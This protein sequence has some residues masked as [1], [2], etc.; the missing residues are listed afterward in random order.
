MKLYDALNRPYLREEEATK[1]LSTG[2]T[3]LNYA[4]SGSYKYGLET[5]SVVLVSGENNS[6]R[7]TFGLTVLAEASIN[8]LFSDYTLYY[9]D[10]EGKTVDIRGFLGNRAGDRI[11]SQKL[12]HIDSFWELCSRRKR[13]IIV[14]D[15]LDGLM[16]GGNTW[17]KNN[18]CAK[19]VFDCVRKNNSIV[20]ITLQA[21]RVN[22]K[23]ITAG[24]Y[25]PIFYSD[26]LVRLSY[27]G[28]LLA[29]RGKT[30]MSVGTNTSI[31]PLK[32]KFENISIIEC[33][34]PINVQFGYD[35]ALSMLLYFI[36]EG[37]IA[38]K[39]GVYSFPV[40]NIVGDFYVFLK[41]FRDNEVNIA[42]NFREIIKKENYG[43]GSVNIPDNV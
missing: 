10:T 29:R 33:P 18:D 8:P 6:G 21:K 41:Y 40:Y 22:G 23:I 4:L 20:V 27:S 1:K 37:I 34:A 2:L 14:L 3:V 28:E 43:L 32:S 12:S 31:T 13:S 11:Y 42:Q 19:G 35:N 38:E 39:D 26:T 15:S 25:A 36:K 7:T 17:R 30:N 24:G 9:Y 16:V 5:G